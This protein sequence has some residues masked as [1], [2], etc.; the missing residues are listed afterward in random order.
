MHAMS[1][2]NMKFLLTLTLVTTPPSYLMSRLVGWLADPDLYMDSL[3]Y[4]YVAH[5]LTED[6]IFLLPYYYP[7]MVIK[8]K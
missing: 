7:S 4:R 1:T 2:Y 5:N 6:N 3:G 8:V